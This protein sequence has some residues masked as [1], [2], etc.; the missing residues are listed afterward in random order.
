MRISALRLR[1]IRRFD[2]DGLAIENIPPGLSML[3]EPNEFGK[4]TLFDVLRVALFEKHSTRGAN[5]KRLISVSGAA[6][7]IELDFVVNERKYR[8]RKQFMKS[9]FAELLHVD[10]GEKLKADGEAHDW[11]I[12]QI[13][14]TKAGEGPTGLL[15][16]A[17]GNSMDSPEAGDSGKTL[18]ASLLEQEV[19]EVTGGERA[20][21][22]L[23]KVQDELSQ[24]ITKTGQPKAGPHKTVLTNLEQA[25]ASIDEINS[26]LSLAENLLVELAQLT[27]T[28]KGLEDPEQVNRIENELKNARV[29]L[30]E[31]EK[32]HERIT[33][34]YDRLEDKKIEVTRSKT[35]LDNFTEQTVEA[36]NILN[37]LESMPESRDKYIE[38]KKQ[39]ESDLAIHRS[40]VQ[41]LGQERTESETIVKLCMRAEKEAT[42]RSKSESLRQTLEKAEN[43]HQKLLTSKG[44]LTRNQISD[45]V[46]DKIKNS[47]YKLER[48]RERLSADSTTITPHLTSLGENTVKLDGEV[49]SGRTDLSGN[50]LLQ[51]GDYGEISIEA[52]IPKEVKKEYENTKLMVEDM[53]SSYEVG[54]LSEAER[55]ANDYREISNTIKHLEYRKKEYAPQGISVLQEAYQA[56][57]AILSDDL[58]SEDVIAKLPKPEAAE[59]NWELIRRTY[60][61]AKDK[62]SELEIEYSKTQSSLNQINSEIEQY[63]GQYGGIVAK[64][65][66]R[67]TWADEAKRLQAIYWSKT[68]EKE[69]LELEIEEQQ[70]ATPTLEV[71]RDDV[72]RFEQAKDSNTKKLH[73][74]KIREA[75]VRRDLVAISDKGFEEELANLNQQKQRFE[76]QK[77]AIESHISALQL[78]ESLL[79]DS[80]KSLQEQFLKP[81]SNELG[82]LL[83][84]VFPNAEIALGGDFN[85][86]EL[87][88]SGRV[89]TIDT[90]SGGTREQIAVLTRLAFAQLM[91]KRGREMPVI[92]DDALVW[93]DDKRLEDVFRALRS[94][95]RDIQC[96]V[97]TCH[98]KGFSTLGAP[99]LEVQ[100]WPQTD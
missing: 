91:A 76:K 15:W 39:L 99:V 69:E 13:G 8:I 75:E 34:S 45:S 63:K 100:K 41:Q 72:Q 37:K 33:I 79:Q 56:E 19:G 9:P 78:L 4:S 49:I 96:I 73:S 31:A 55:K 66:E 59:Q 64:I 26:K 77:S 61:D 7:L 44:K 85:A 43:T 11:M 38:R 53:L 42:A 65:G 32:A 24:L 97:L 95:A 86:E 94:A 3:A 50:Q 74:K 58:L 12:N 23:K 6:P 90:L 93:C 87:I 21:L 27:Q 46:L 60:D 62:L 92:L 20:R 40:R 28:I 25:N 83:K 81:V 29:R 82:P 5:V 52:S 30:Q 14:A 2:R 1:N 84:I 48:L 68:R 70:N 22:I 98:E 57:C 71:A 67:N 54:S 80:Q 89:D 16:V 36:N 47:H 35:D 88:R 51:L 17:Q 18:L 10:T